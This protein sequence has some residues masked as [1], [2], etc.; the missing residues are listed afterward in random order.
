MD[1]IMLEHEKDYD[2]SV[3]LFFSILEE[4]IGVDKT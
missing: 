3:I 4:F 2:S 1:D